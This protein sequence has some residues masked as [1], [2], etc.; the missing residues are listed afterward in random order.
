MEINGSTEPLTATNGRPIKF[1]PGRLQQIKNLVERGMSREEI[2]ET[3]GATVGS[4]QVTCSRVG[5]SLRRPQGV[6]ALRREEEPKEQPKPAEPR[7]RFAL[8]MEYR[9]RERMLELPLSQDLLGRLAIE[10]H[11]ANLG[12]AEMT[13]KLLN[14]AGQADLFEK[15]R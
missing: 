9:G 6:V 12:V 15:L 14:A 4:L 8:R 3:I 5:I 2:A 13:A 10:A 11:F 7:A 1:T